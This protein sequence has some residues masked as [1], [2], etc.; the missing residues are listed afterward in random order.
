M[1]EV[2]KNW[3]LCD[4]K[5]TPIDSIHKSTWDIGGKYILKHNSNIKELYR[6]IQM[7]NL[8]ATYNIPVAI[9]EKTIEGQWVTPDGTFCLMKKMMG[10]HIDFFD[11]PNMIIEFGKELAKLHIA[12]AII[13][14]QIE[15]N[16][17]NFINEWQN[18]IKPGLVN[19][20]DDII[21]FIEAQF[22]D[23]Y[24]KLP[25][26]LIHRDVHAQNVLFNDGKLSGWLDFDINCRNVR[27]FDLAYLLGGLLCGK[28]ND[29]TG[30]ALWK[31]LYQNLVIGYESNN[32][33]SKDE[34]EILPFMMIAIELL[35]VTFWNNQ[36]NIEYRDNSITLVKWLFDK[37]KKKEFL[38]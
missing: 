37:C 29:L 27:V 10:N 24:I 8:L 2:L 35:F 4:E 26:Q 5:V 20:P 1:I 21:A 32:P 38:L 12:L 34:K 19:I 16:D 33:L 7:A 22:F 36:D 11:T 9:Y 23:M 3:N 18:Y 17:N 6:G 28:I 15:C 13:E 14:P 30:I 25:R 31:K